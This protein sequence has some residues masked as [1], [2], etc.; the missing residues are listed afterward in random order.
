MVSK[1]NQNKSKRIF[2]EFSK[3]KF[4]VIG[5]IMLDSYIF[6]SSNRIS[7]EA[8]IP[9]V[10][11]N[12]MN[13][14]LGGAAN[15]ALNLSSLGAKVCLAG[16]IGYDSEGEL[17]E[18]ILIDN[19]I[20]SNLIFKS[21]DRQTTQKS[22]IIS[23]GHHVLRL[24]RETRVDVNSS[25]SKKIIKSISAI[26]S[27]FDGIILEDYNKGVF[28]KKTIPQLIELCNLNNKAVYVDPKH[29]NFLQYSDIRLMK[30]NL[31]EF[32]NALNLKKFN[33]KSGFELLKKINSDILLITK[34]ADGISL[35]QDSLHYEAPTQARKIHDVS[36]AGDTVI[37]VFALCDVCGLD[38]K[39]SADIANYAAGVTCEEVGVVPVSI[40]SIKK[41]ISTIDN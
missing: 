15:V 36:G 21:S 30:P 19:G 26:I 24:D 33:E 1:M 16:V 2:N 7:P 4:L 13:H 17:L 39:I 5:D 32:C 38:S 22:R 9:I 37:A 34:G 3:K 23:N 6:G 28:N 35:F 29:D 10:D 12:D 27:E 31:L 8:P 18:K 20:D 11:L 41:F 14:K 25:I 40:N